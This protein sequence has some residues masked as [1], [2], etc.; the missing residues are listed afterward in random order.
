MSV[1]KDITPGGQGYMP[2]APMIAESSIN[3]HA[4]TQL[5]E[6]H[7]EQPLVG[8]KPPRREDL[9]PS[10]AQMLPPQEDDGTHGWYGGMVNTCGSIIGF[11]GAIPCC[12]SYSP[13]VFEQSELT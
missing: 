2:S 8:V 4:P 6:A 1:A 9:Q 10:Y 3:T 13:C 7:T 11:L 5:S 12:K